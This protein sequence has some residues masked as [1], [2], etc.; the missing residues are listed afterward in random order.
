MF[1][2]NSDF[3][4]NYLQNKPETLKNVHYFKSNLNLF[5]TLKYSFFK[6]FLNEMLTKLLSL[7]FFSQN[8]IHIRN[9]VKINFFSV[10][11]MFEQLFF[12]HQKIGELKIL[13]SR[14]N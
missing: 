7:G 9:L 10:L 2:P 1:I 14:A 4:E 12:L 3:L 13:T 11:F 8:F 5:E 6:I